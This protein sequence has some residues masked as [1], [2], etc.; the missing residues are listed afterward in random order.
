M[1]QKIERKKIDQARYFSCLQTARNYKVYAELKYLDTLT[2]GKWFCLV[3]R[4]YEAIMPVCYDTK[5]MLQRVIQPT[6]CQQLGV[7]YNEPI[8]E[9]VFDAFYKVL[10]KNRIKNYQFNDDN[11]SQYSFKGKK[12]KN[13]ILNLENTFEK[14]MKNWNKNTKRNVAK[15]KENH[16]T[17][18]YVH[19]PKKSHIQKY[20]HLKKNFAPHIKAKS[21]DQLEKLLHFLLD[22]NQLHFGF[23]HF[24]DQILSGASFVE[25][26]KGMYYLNGVNAPIAK[27]QFASFYLFGT[28]IEQWSGKYHFLDFEGSD[29]KGIE[30]FFKGWGAERHYYK[31]I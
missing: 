6:F 12:R 1:I 22:E 20:I 27:E 7:F 5:W 4:D 21:L 10:K 31:R 2:D 23:V 11:V 29:D 24:K 9:K 30:R 26:Q 13:Y 15:S 25:S 3:Y 16:L 18:E 8:E 17:L 19:Q 14:Q 28:L